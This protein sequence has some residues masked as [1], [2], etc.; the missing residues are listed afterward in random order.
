MLKKIEIEKYRC[1]EKT[2]MLMRDCVIIVGKNNAGKSSFIEALRLV[3][4]ATKKCKNSTYIEPPL[5]LGLTRSMKGFKLPVERLKIDLR[6]IVYYYKDDIAKVTATFENGT[7]FVIYVNQDVAY[8]VLY[9]TDNKLISS[10]YKA[11]DA[12]IPTISI[13]PQIGLI[14]ENERKLRELTVV[15]DIDTY[16]SSRHFRNE[17]Y[18]SNEFFA[19]FKKLAEDTW[20]GL[21]VKE[22]VYEPAASDYISLFIEDSKFPAEIG[23]MGSGIQMWLQIIWFICRSKQSETIILDEP[24]VYMHPDLQVKLL[25]IAKSMF[26]QVVIA[27]HSVEIISNV[28]PRNI[29]AID[30]K[31]RQMTYASEINEI[32]NIVNDIGSSYNLSLTKLGNANKC[33]FAERDDIHILQQFYN[34]LLPKAISSVETVPSLPLG[35]LTRVN[36][37][38]GAARLF[39]ENSDGQFMCYAILNRGF[40]P[41][42]RIEEIKKH[43]QENHLQLHIWE[44]TELENYL[45]KPKILYKVIKDSNLSYLDFR[46]ALEAFVDIHK[47]MTIDSITT[48]IMEEDKSM[49]VGF[50]AK[51]AGEFVNFRWTDLNSKLSIVSGKYL[52]HALNEWIKV[53]YETSCSMN[54]IFSV[55]GPEDIEDE[56]KE[57]LNKLVL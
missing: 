55:M 24:D 45:L 51:Q 44:K 42:S 25:K 21:R 28:S 20:P 49:S 12:D 38:Y 37:A 18:L 54:K 13:L 57:L 31:S 40:Y 33:I 15:E 17:M 30:K 48:K 14:K 43:A 29:I 36:E 3:A 10:R 23:L 47:E 8:A 32:Q 34:I 7:K 52:L 19:D 26:K 6:G 4:M 16:L 35:G 22:L 5:T 41:K 9:N 11:Q 53:F 1:F 46:N 39:H 56:M 27:T 2:K 50:A